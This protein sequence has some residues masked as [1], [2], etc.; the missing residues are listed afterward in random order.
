MSSSAAGPPSRGAAS[1]T[2]AAADLMP[3]PPTALGEAVKKKI[4]SFG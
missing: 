1:V 4:N 3:C 2:A